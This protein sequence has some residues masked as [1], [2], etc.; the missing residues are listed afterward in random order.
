MRHEI[1]DTNENAEIIS[2]S[3]AERETNMNRREFVKGAFAVA[4]AVAL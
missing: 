2:I 3:E 4:C 1:K